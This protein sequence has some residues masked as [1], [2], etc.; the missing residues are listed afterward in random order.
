MAKKNKVE[1]DVVVDDKGSTKKVGLGAKKAAEGLDKVDKSS[2]NAQKGIKGVAQTASAGGKNFAGMSRGM[3]GLVGAY[4]SF[5][6]QMFALTAA[7]GFFKRAGDLS[8]MQQGQVAYA[9]ATGIAMKSLANDI[10]AATGAQITFRDASQAAAI[11]TAAGLSAD[12]L[13]RLGTAA[14]DASAVLG[15]DVTDAFNRLVRGVTKAE[16][17]LLDELGI[18]LR[19]DTAS[20]NYARSLGK[21]A[22]DLTQF[23]KSQAVANEVLSQAE[24]K[25]SAILAVTGGGAVNQF[26]KL[27]KS[28]DDV[29][30]TIQNALLP[31]ANVLAKVLGDTPILAAAGFAMLASGPLKAM[32]FSL[33][34]S[35]I[36]QKA[37]AKASV[38]A[39]AQ[40]KLD[41]LQT[42]KAIDL[43]K[44][45]IQQKA[46]A[47][48]KAEGYT[49][50][51]KVLKNVAATGIIT[52]QARASIK[53]GL[54][55]V[56]L[57]V[58]EST[59]I[60]KGMFKGLTV[61]VVKEYAAMVAR[62]DGLEKAKAAGTVTNVQRMKLA[63]QG[64]TTGIARAGAGITAFASKALAAFGWISIGITLF[65]ALREA[66]KSGEEQTLLMK[67]MEDHRD[68]IKD[69]VKEYKHFIEVQRI[70]MKEGTGGQGI[71]GLGAV[72]G[73]L[74]ALN[75]PATM[76]L[77]EDYASFSKKNKTANYEERKSLF[78]LMKATHGMNDARTVAAGREW[79][80]AS[81]RVGEGGMLRSLTKYLDGPDAISDAEINAKMLMDIQVEAIDQVVRQFG[82]NK[83][84]ENFRKLLTEGGGSIDE[85]QAAKDAVDKITAT[86]RSY[87]K[88][89]EAAA[90]ASASFNNSLA[91]TNSAENAILKQKEIIAAAQELRANYQASEDENFAAKL[92]FLGPSNLLDKI[93]T[94]EVDANL[95]IKRLTTINEA[96]AKRARLLKMATLEVTKAGRIEHPIYKARE[97][98]IAQEIVAMIK[99]R[100]IQDEINILNKEVIGK[101]KE[102]SIAQKRKLLDLNVELILAKEVESI[103]E[104]KVRLSEQL[105]EVELQIYNLKSDQ[106]LIQYAKQL[107]DHDKSS[108]DILKRRQKIETALA[109][110]R[111]K[112]AVKEQEGPGGI[113][114]DRARY[115]AEAEAEEKKRGGKWHMAQVKIIEDEAKIKRKTQELDNKTTELKW[116][117]LDAEL[118]RETY[119]AQN[120]KN[121]FL[122]LA[123]QQAQAADD[124]MIKVGGSGS[125]V[126]QETAESQVLRDKSNAN[127]KRGGSD[128]DP[129]L[130][131]LRKLRETITS[132]RQE[133]AGPDGN[134]AALIQLVDD[135]EE[136]RVRVLNQGIDD[137]VDKANKL[138]PIQV[139]MKDLGQ[140]VYD[141][142]NSAF[143]AMVTGAKS[144]KDAFADMA[145]SIL[146]D[147]TAMIVKAMILQMFGG[148]GFGNF[149]GLGKARNGGVFEQGKKLSGYATGGVAKGSTSGYPVMMHGTEA[150]VPLPNGKSIPVQMSGN[151]GSTNN[152]V[153]NI[154]TDGQSS[155]EGSSGPDMDKLGGAIATAVQIE[156]Q[157]QKR[158][159]GIL[160]PYGVA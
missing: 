53:K 132:I 44:A 81:G 32:G 152:I 67:K 86:Y 33:K 153:V 48:L 4:A 140:S 159:G 50:N 128:I 123:A 82:G 8:V 77:M 85:V 26:A 49:G 150:I 52:P 63:W 84:F 24:E 106:K 160:N 3:G 15:R 37:A 92:G 109:A 46:L 25:Y 97:V 121:D 62:L 30:M 78:L 20:E 12:Q 157:N 55:A 101:G 79:N 57:D 145:K 56:N 23:E 93:S 65:L 41:I 143:T 51:S 133:N 60:Q 125:S 1:I 6:A 66:M 105:F 122:L 131:N 124:A 147:L 120:I 36:T 113:L 119:R 54:S 141:N 144:A 29:V 110:Q 21:A 19:L 108:L 22:G 35:A 34:D 129:Q 59:V 80:L 73:L 155:K 104:T 43:E 148:S 94:D 137:L 96:T 64:L 83:A 117:L 146:K 68:K 74:G 136:E 115:T 114:Q 9:S 107:L 149:L 72:G 127:L 102:G 27:G 2:R 45:A 39:Y 31:V 95:E 100:N 118:E 112:D 91:P 134:F 142:M 89:I 98:A 42:T 10:T 7:F 71:A 38:A 70:M 99:R 13:V 5:A 126:F 111:V 87:A 116:N 156:L 130:E 28:M 14:K 88:A 135:E 69:L 16:P 11:G 47:T 139:M 90:D 18:I 158:S 75:T 76:Q 138:Q 151:G 17:E 61:G 154:S 103:A 58:H 40:R